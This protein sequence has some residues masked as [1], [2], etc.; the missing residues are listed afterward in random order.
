MVSRFD[1]GIDLKNLT[2]EEKRKRKSEGAIYSNL[3]RRLVNKEPLTGQTLD[4]A[5]KL[6]ASDPNS[7]DREF[8]NKLD[9]ITKKLKSGESLDNS[10]ASLVIDVLLVHDRLSR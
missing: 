1:Y 2:E 8:S 10:E 7:E 9:E 6:V 3:E 5:L 4:Y